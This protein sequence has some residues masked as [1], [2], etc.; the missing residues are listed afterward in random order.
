MAREWE[1]LLAGIG[2]R[3][4]LTDDPTSVKVKLLQEV[5]RSRAM[6][7]SA[8]M[9]TVL[10]QVLQWQHLFSFSSSIS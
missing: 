6:G 4:K 8:Q 3:Y 5:L 2:A 9:V 10:P 1:K 7:T